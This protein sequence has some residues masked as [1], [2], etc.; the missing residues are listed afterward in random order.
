MVSYGK[1]P[2]GNSFNLSTCLENK[3][4]FE[5]LSSQLVIVSR[6]FFQKRSRFYQSREVC[7]AKR[8]GEGL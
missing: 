5:I 4:Y 1:F 2:M 6:A 3:G 8:I 7:C